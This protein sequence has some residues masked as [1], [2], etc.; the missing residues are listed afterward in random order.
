MTSAGVLI[1]GCVERERADDRTT[2]ERP[3]GISA[4]ENGPSW[5]IQ[6]G[7]KKPYLKGSFRAFATDVSFEYI[8]I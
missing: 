6:R 4:V 3:D 2:R 8:Y 5:R 7:G 1:H